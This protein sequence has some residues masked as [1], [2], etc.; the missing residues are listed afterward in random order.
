MQTYTDSTVTEG[1]TYYYR[2]RNYDSAATP[3]TYSAYATAA[4]V[5]VPP[6]G[7]HTCRSGVFAVADA[8]AATVLWVD[9][10]TSD[11]A[12]E[13]D[14]SAQRRHNLDDPHDDAARQQHELH[15]HDRHGRP[16]LRVSR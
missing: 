1:G 4:A 10:S 13:V 6:A 15:R 9:N 12:Y 8:Y 3:P 16:G 5:T 7:T 2:I 14:R 11:T